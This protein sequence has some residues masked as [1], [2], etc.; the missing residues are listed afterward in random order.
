MRTNGRPE[1]P[2]TPRNPVNMD[3]RIMTFHAL[4]PSIKVSCR[5]G[6]QL[7]QALESVRG[8]LTPRPGGEVYWCG[9]VAA[10][11]PGPSCWAIVRAFVA[12]FNA[13]LL[14]PLGGHCASQCPSPFYSLRESQPSVLGCVF[15]F[16]PA[17][18]TSSFQGSC[19]PS[20]SQ[21]KSTTQ[22]A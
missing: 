2:S 19:L 16:G 12:L 15:D 22:R 9:A 18:K 11:T 5:A 20:M 10:F 7:T 3:V 14:V 1:L 4:T 17:R 8:A 21:S 13:V 6:V